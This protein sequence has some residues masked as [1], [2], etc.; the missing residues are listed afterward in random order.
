M[1]PNSGR[2]RD[3]YLAARAARDDFAARFYLNLVPPAEQ[4]DL[5]AKADV[6]EAV[7]PLSKLLRQHRGD[8][9]NP[10]LAL[11]PLIEI[12]TVKKAKLGPEDPDTLDALD[13]P[14]DLHWRLRQFDKAIP[15][16]EEIVKICEAKFGRDSLQ[17]LD[18]M[19]KLGN[20]FWPMGQYDKAIP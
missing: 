19:D 6:E 11:S 13:K 8:G 20:R 5:V 10:S 7:A 4:K 1:E 2:Y 9:G 12:V 17:T 18:A 15:V 16:F 14:S 3:G